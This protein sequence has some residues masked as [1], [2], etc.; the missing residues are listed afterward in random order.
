MKTLIF[1]KIEETSQQRFYKLSEAITKA[2]NPKFK[3]EEEKE[4]AQK[5]LKE[6][7]KKCLT[8]KIE[9]VCVSDAHTHV[10]RLLFPAIKISE[11]KYT[12]LSYNQMDGKHTFMI[13]GGS[14]RDVHPDGVYLRRLARANNF[15]FK[16]KES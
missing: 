15:K 9:I 3:W 10:E 14:Q 6:E 7:F 11:S 2:T 8:E 16:I 1:E 13:H 4:F 5:R 12:C